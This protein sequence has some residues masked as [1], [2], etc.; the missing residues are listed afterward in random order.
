MRTPTLLLTMAAGLAGLAPVRADYTAVFADLDRPIPDGSAVGISDSR[1]ITSGLG[2]PLLDVRVTLTLSG[3]Y[4]GDLYVALLHEG[5]TTVLLNRPGR[6]AEDLFGYADAGLGV[7]FSDAAGPTRDVHN[8]RLVANGDH[9]T[10]LT[11]PLTGI[12]RP[13]GRAVD[14]EVVLDTDVPSSFFSAFLD[15]TPDGVWT[16]FLADLSPVGETVLEEWALELFSQSV[17][18]PQAVLPGVALLGW[19]FG[20]LVRRRPS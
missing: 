20:R 12:W 7:T 6:R 15:D 13:D 1:T 8:Y 19:A 18:E 3:G 5:S 14:P 11:D 17:P 16:L 2:A 4:L 10:P 9:D